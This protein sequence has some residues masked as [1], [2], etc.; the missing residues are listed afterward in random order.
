[1]AKNGHIY[2]VF[3]KVVN[4]AEYRKHNADLLFV[5]ISIFTYFYDE[6]RSFVPVP[7]VTTRKNTTFAMVKCENANREFI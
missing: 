6:Y 3:T 1:M 5:G 4:L 7:R 2:I